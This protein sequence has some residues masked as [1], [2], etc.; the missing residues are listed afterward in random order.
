VVHVSQPQ[1]HFGEA[2]RGSEKRSNQE[3]VQQRSAKSR[4][5][6]S[7]TLFLLARMSIPQRRDEE[8]LRKA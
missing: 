6:D 7:V 1:A 4:N 8:F 5:H 2:A 3:K